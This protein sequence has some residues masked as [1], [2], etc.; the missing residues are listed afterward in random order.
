[1][2]SIR[3]M[4]LH[5]RAAIFASSQQMETSCLNYRTVNNAGSAFYDHVV[6]KILLLKR[7]SIKT[8]RNNETTK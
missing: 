7:L 8:A 2:L 1:M 3:Q 6:V 4:F 5:L